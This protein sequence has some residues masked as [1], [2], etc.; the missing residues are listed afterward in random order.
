MG[1]K[2]EPGKFDCHAKAEPDEPL[3]TLIAR[4]PFAARLV[5]LWASLSEKDL[6]AASHQFACLCHEASKADSHSLAHFGKISEAEY[7][8]AAMDAWRTNRPSED[9]T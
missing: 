6:A 3:F 4:D 5:R 9:K 8:A 7:C 1:T 2:N